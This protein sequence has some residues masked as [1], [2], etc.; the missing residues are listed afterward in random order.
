MV[1]GVKGVVVMVMKV[2]MNREPLIP[3]KAIE[4]AIV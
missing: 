4:R 1:V 2:A 3:T